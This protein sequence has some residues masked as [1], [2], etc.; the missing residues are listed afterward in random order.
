MHI[1][2]KIN[3]C[4]CKMFGKILLKKHIAQDVGAVTNNELNILLLA[5]I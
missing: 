2:G 4:E 5:F 1:R 3:K